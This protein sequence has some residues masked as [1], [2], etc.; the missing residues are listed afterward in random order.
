MQR[1]GF[2]PCLPA[3]LLP[4]R[5]PLFISCAFR[6]FQQVLRL[7][8]FVPRYK[9]FVPQYTVGTVFCVNINIFAL[10]LNDGRRRKF[11]KSGGT[12]PEP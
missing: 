12:G 3:S 10:E 2:D 6:I 5:G 7:N 1:K 4:L 9:Y 11:I 8:L